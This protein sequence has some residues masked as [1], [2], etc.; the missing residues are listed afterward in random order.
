LVALKEAF[1]KL[2]KLTLSNALENVI[3]K[4][5]GLVI[6]STT[7]I[8]RSENKCGVTGDSYCIA[9]HRL[10]WES[11]YYNNCLYKKIAID[12]EG[13]IKNCPSMKERYGH[14]TETTLTSV[15]QS[16]AFRK[17]WEITKDKIEVCSQCELRYVCQDCRAYTIETGNPYSK[18]L[19]CRYDPR[20]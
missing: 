17:Y 10:Y 3:Y 7:E 18:P 13:Y 6:I 14:V 11:M 19:K 15:V 12:K 8:I 1:P 20:K 2:S 4:H 5:D 9:E 16:D